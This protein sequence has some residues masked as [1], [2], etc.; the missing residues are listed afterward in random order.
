[1]NVLK[2]IFSI[3]CTVAEGSA[4]QF[5]HNTL[6][7]G[8]VVVSAAQKVT[9]DHHLR[10]ASIAA[11]LVVPLIFLTVVFSLLSN[12]A[13][14]ALPVLLLTAGLGFWHVRAIH[15]IVGPT[16]LSSGSQKPFAT[17]S[18]TTTSSPRKTLLGLVVVNVALALLGGSFALLSDRSVHVV[19]GT[20]ACSIATLLALVFSGLWIKAPRS[21]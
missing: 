4:F 8:S 16:D 17:S 11:A 6:P 21:A 15:R 13:W 12:N 1:M 7:G 5:H 19:F 3:E 10:K 2:T 14:G 18:A 20:I 9:L